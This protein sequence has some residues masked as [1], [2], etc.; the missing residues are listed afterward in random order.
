MGATLLGIHTTR[1]SNL[2]AHNTSH[3]A[4]IGLFTQLQWAD[5][6]VPSLCMKGI[7]AEPL[8]Y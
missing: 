3:R 2:P 5:D 6:I 8:G 1:H 7:R 4:I